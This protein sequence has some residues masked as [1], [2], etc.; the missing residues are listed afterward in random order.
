MET[1]R[2]SI[3]VGPRRTFAHVTFQ[4]VAEST[5]TF[6]TPRLQWPNEPLVGVENGADLDGLGLMLW[7]P[8]YVVVVNHLAGARS[9]LI[10]HAS[11]MLLGFLL[12]Q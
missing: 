1:H 8:R 7:S 6:I 5:K 4:K 10:Q 2:S 11:L 12:S 3:C 9:H